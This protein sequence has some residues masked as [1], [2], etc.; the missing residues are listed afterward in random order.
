MREIIITLL[1]LTLISLSIGTAF[2]E[3]DNIVIVEKEPTI[4][5]GWGT[6]AEGG[7]LKLN[8]NNYIVVAGGEGYDFEIRV[9]SHSEKELE[10]IATGNIPSNGITFR[11][12]Y[13]YNPQGGATSIY[14]STVLVTGEGSLLLRET[15]TGRLN[16]VR[17]MA[18][19]LSEI[20][21]SDNNGSIN[22][23]P[24]TPETP[25]D[26]DTTPPTTTP[27]DED[28]TPPTTTPPDEDTTPPEI[29]T[30]P[31]ETTPDEDTTPP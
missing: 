15:T 6:S 23:P 5:N 1:F 11:M 2:A 3:D 7:Y 25:P 16:N 17:V 9:I 12:Y 27:P 18:P 30:T 31:P 29:P 24:T 26:E 19:D 14:E 13:Q 4:N 22:P 10:I 21:T 8:A 20:E 28:T